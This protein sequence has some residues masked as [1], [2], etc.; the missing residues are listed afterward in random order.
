MMSMRAF[1]TQWQRRS[2]DFTAR[3]SM[4]TN[5]A[6][7]ELQRANRKEAMGVTVLWAGASVYG[8]AS[9]LLVGDFVHHSQLAVIAIQLFVLLPAFL[10]GL[11]FARSGANGVFALT[12]NATS[13]PYVLAFLVAALVVGYVV[14][15]GVL[16]PDESGY[17]FQ[18]EIFADGELSAPAPTGATDTPETPLPVNF[19]HHVV[20]RGRWFSKYPV[21]WPAVLALPEKFGLGWAAAPVLGALLVAITGLVARE[22]F[23]PL[24]IAPSLWIAV[25]SPFWLATCVGRLSEA[26]CAVLV[27]AACLC[28]LR[29]MRTRNVGAFALMYA[30]LVPNFLVRP[31]TALVTSA[32]LGVAALLWSRR[33]RALLFRVLLLSIV[34]ATAAVGLTLSLNL[35]YTGSFWLSPYA[36]YKG[37][38]V[39]NEVTA[40]PAR[41]VSNLLGAWR[42][43]AQSMLTYAFPFVFLLAAYGLWSH[44]RS[45][46]AWVLASIL[47]ALAVGYLADAGGPSSIIGERYWFEGFFGVAILAGQGLVTLIS[48]WRIPKRLAVAGIAAITAAQ[49]LMT[50]AAINVLY[51]YSQPYAAVRAAA[52]QNQN[53]DCAVFIANTPT[54][55]YSRNMDMNGANW[56]RANVFYFNDPG[57]EQ[58][59][60]WAN[61]Y[62][63][64]HWTVVTYDAESRRAFAQSYR[65][66]TPDALPAK[67]R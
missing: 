5:S 46:A 13:R 9:A 3:T 29:A 56:R 31:F 34:A 43:S 2:E 6:T 12:A 48:L 55:L 53:C 21:G 44:R 1:L 60:I 52:K 27:A 45:W 30:F 35:L 41:I 28:C 66:A 37:V 51:F 4:L 24:T 32:V 54:A 16:I 61:R 8:L 50:L 26:L 49:I 39:P 47:P 20:Y 18:A 19:A 15:R 38:A 67:P 33:D 17:R 62:G 64:H 65:D 57:P 22:A 40:S 63:W 59:Q 58:R 23:G 7:G 11:R 10:Y 25:L 42:F 14:G 36:L